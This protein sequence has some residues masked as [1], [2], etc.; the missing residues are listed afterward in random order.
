MVGEVVQRRAGHVTPVP[1][2]TG[3]VPARIHNGTSPKA[4]NLVSLA[5]LALIAEPAG[6]LSASTR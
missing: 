3:V 1:L 5:V 4:F 6:R 2:D